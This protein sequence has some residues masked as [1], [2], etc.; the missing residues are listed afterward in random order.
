MATLQYFESIVE[1]RRQILEQQEIARH[2]SKSQTGVSTM[3]GLKAS[4]VVGL[5]AGVRATLKD[6][7]TPMP[8]ATK[9]SSGTTLP[10]QISSSS[11]WR[12]KK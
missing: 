3:H 12:N 10:S 4:P 1:G 8:A 11:Y 2:T 7:L 6:L 5:N 9:S